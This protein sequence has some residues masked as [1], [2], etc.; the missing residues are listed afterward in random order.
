M[1]VVAF[2]VGTTETAFA[3]MTDQYE[4]LDFGKVPNDY[5]LELKTIFSYDVFVYEKFMSYGMTIGQ[6]TID[7]IEW[8][9]RYKQRA[10]DVGCKKIV[11]LPRKEVKINLCGT[12]K[13]KDT[14]IRQ[15]LIDRFA[16]FDFKN[17]K[18]TKN[19]RD[20]FYGVSADCWSSIALCV[21]YLDLS[22]RD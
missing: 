7:S 14:N 1:N 2:D 22:K 18:G 10:I 6:T 12:M 20:V 16:K 19:N 13:A 15:A 11:A 4:L 9:G 3:I 5:L 21:T 8:N 17:G